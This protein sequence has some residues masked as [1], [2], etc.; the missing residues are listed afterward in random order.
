MPDLFGKLAD[1]PCRTK[2][3]DAFNAGSAMLI[4]EHGVIVTVDGKTGHF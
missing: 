2:S 4:G 3:A 1:R